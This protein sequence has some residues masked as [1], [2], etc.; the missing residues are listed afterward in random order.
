LAY[1]YWGSTEGYPVFYFHGSPSSRLEGALAHAAAVKHGFKLVAIDRPG[2]GRSAFQ[3][4]RR[5]TDW[6]SDVVAL[7]DHLGFDRFGVAGHSGAGPHLFACGAFIDPARITF[8]GALGPWGPIASPGIR[9]KMNALD[10]FY[11]GVARRMPWIMRASFAPLGWMAKFL[12]KQFFAALEGAVSP[13]DKVML[14]EPSFLANFRRMELEA[15]RQGGRGAAHEALISFSD[16]GFDIAEVRVPTHI[17]LGEEDIF[18]SDA[19]GRY[20]A[21][22]IPGVQLTTVRGKGHFNIENWDD[23]FAACK[24]HIR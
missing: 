14:A 17:W 5:F 4:S 19:M 7:A 23:I 15:F 2:F 11:A 8:I 20:I 18:V 3:A 10:R 21:E 12:P 9:A 13:A 24:T 6:P 1:Q 22:R 16:W